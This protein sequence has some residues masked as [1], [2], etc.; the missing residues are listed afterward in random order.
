MQPSCVISASLGHFR[1]AT[2]FTA[3]QGATGLPASH[4]KHCPPIN[5]NIIYYS[6]LR[7]YCTCDKLQLSA[8]TAI[9]LSGKNH[10]GSVMAQERV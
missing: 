2:A 4:K 5:Y 8:L 3:D 7:W 1:S 6:S 10:M 9:S